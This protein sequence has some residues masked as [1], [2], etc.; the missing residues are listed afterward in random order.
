MEAP[1]FL[2]DRVAMASSSGRFPRKT[3]RVLAL[4]E[5]RRRRQS[6]RVGVQ[7]ICLHAWRPGSSVAH[8][9]LRDAV[10]F[11]NVPDDHRYETKP[12]DQM[13]D[14]IAAAIVDPVQ[15]A[16]HMLISGGTP[17]PKDI[18]YLQEVYER[19]LMEFPDLAIDIMMVPVERLLDVHKLKD[20]GVHELSINIE[21]FDR[22]G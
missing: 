6:R 5:V 19:T 15:P 8:P 3:G 10:H 7:P 9:G 16:R 12:I 22:E 21:I 1:P 14:A 13:V 4:D 20:L 2:L 11:C 17:V 18:P